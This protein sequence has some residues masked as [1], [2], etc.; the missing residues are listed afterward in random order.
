M[1]T[2]VTR[3]EFK[4]YIRML[5]DRHDMADDNSALW[6][7]EHDLNGEQCQWFVFAPCVKVSRDNRYKSD[8]WEWC[9]NN[10]KGFV[11]CFMSNSEDNQEVWGFTD[12]DDIDWWMLKW[13]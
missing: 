4:F 12:L 1:T 6:I 2:I 11:R 3:E 13:T 5:F 7:P 10:L 9:S 8:Y